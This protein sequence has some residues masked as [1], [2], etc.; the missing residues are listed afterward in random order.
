MTASKRSPASH[1]GAIRQISPTEIGVGIDRPDPCPECLPERGIGN[2]LGHV[3]SPA[4]DPEPDPVLGNVEQVVADRLEVGVQLGQRWQ[5]PP[6]LVAQPVKRAGVLTRLA[7]GVHCPAGIGVGEQLPARGQR[8]AILPEPVEV[9][10]G[11]AVL[12]DVVEG[13]EA[14]PGVVEDAIQDDPHAPGVDR[15]DELAQGC[16]AAEQW[17][18]LQVVVRV[19]AVVRGGG[20][21]RGQVQ[22]GDPQVGQH[23]QVLGDAQQVAALEAVEGRWIGPRLEMTRLGH[24]VAGGEAVGEDLIEDGIANPARRVD[25]R[26]SLASQPAPGWAADQGSTR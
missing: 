14:T 15:V 17:I 11:E 26:C 9:G 24:A 23:R 18:D 19:I 16:V 12:E 13:P 7:R 6:G 5:A 4:V 21:D 10:R 2:L 20:E 25:H 3:Q 22:G 8:I 1:S